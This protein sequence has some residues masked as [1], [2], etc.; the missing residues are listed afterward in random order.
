MLCGDNSI[1]PSRCVRLVLE[2]LV[3]WKQARRRLE[4]TKS[5]AAR[6]VNNL[7]SLISS[8]FPHGRPTRDDMVHTT[9]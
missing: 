9:Q 1:G 6:E 2:E 5:V 7:L 8:L 3:R 4:Q